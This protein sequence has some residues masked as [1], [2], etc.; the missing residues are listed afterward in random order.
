MKRLLYF[1]LF[2]FLVGWLT[3]CG[4]EPDPTPTPTATPS[5][6]PEPTATATPTFTATPTETSTPTETPTPTHT[7]TPTATNTPSPTPTIELAEIQ[8]YDNFGFSLQPPVGYEVADQDGQFFVQSADGDVIIS[9]SLEEE[10][11]TDPPE[12]VLFDYVDAVARSTGSEVEP[13]E[14][15]IY[16]VD[17]IEGAAADIT[18]DLFGAPILGQAVAIILPDGR[19]FFALGVARVGENELLWAEEGGPAFNGLLSSVTFLEATP[20]PRP[21]SATATPASTSNSACPVS[22]DASYGYTQ[23]NPIRVGGDVFGGP[24]RA[25]AYLDTLRGPNGET[26]SYTRNGSVVNDTT[27]LDAYTI[28]GLAQATTLY[29]DQYSYETLKAPVGFTCSSP[30]PLSAP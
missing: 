2:L 9:F 29:V 19:L 8:T 26:L 21:P 30:F 23:G 12:E 5:A 4:G 10:I 18:G 11:F 13:G 17:G 1:G 28:N 14:P 25:R 22:T 6:T 20:T 3:A 15:Y 7:P 24:A 27:I 16:M